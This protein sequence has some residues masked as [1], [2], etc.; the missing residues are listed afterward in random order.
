MD[1]VT[2]KQAAF[3]IILNGA[4]EILLCHRTDYDLWNMPGGK[5]ESSE[6]PW[7]AVIR[8]VR[9]ETGFDVEVV[10]LAGVYSKP[11]NDEVVF[12]FLCK[13]VGG[14]FKYN[15]EADQIKYFSLD[16]IP[17]NTSPRQVERIKD[18]FDNPNQLC[19]KKQF[20]KGSIELIKEGKL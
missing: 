11:Q 17:E 6:S 10:K 13:I 2:F 20:G 5:V 12:S 15:E 3:A 4:N 9:E 14:E 16:D 1:Q 7:D 19:M 8:E 18:Y